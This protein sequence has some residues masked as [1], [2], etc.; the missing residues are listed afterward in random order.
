MPWTCARC[1]KVYIRNRS[2]AEQH[3]SDNACAVR[4]RSEQRSSVTETT[5]SPALAPTPV[6]STPA[7]ERQQVER[8]RRGS[9]QTIAL[10]SDLPL[11]VRTRVARDCVRGYSSSAANVCVRCLYLSWVTEAQDNRNWHV[12]V[13]EGTGDDVVNRRRVSRW[14]PPQQ[15]WSP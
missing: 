6:P 7:L 8:R 14:S 10:R 2:H 13:Y 5:V 1:G 3:R 11:A 4:P 15:S 12:I 9:W